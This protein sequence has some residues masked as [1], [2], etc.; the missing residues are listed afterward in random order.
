MSASPRCYTFAE[1][2]EKLRLPKGTF[3]DLR[4]RGKLPFVE[5][6]R[7]RLGKHARY[8][9]DLIDRYLSGEWGR[10]TLLASHGRLKVAR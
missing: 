1:V 7:P 3:H 6:L 10:A 4:K 8:R 5:E 2:L 9:A